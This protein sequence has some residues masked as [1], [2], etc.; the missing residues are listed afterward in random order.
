ME[1]L[2]IGFSTYSGT[3]TAAADWGAPA[4]RKRVRQALPCSYEELFHELGV[5][6]FLLP[7]WELSPAV[8]TALRE[9]RLQRAIGVIYKPETERL[10]HYYYCA[11]PEQFDAIMHLDETRALHPLERTSRWEQGEAPDTY[12]TGM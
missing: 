9:P 5:A 11:L 4:E 3:V 1:T 12:P 6:R 8:R 7:L 10:S 2:L